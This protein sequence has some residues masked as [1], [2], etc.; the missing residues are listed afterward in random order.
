MPKFLT[1]E[2]LPH[3]YN[4]SDFSPGTFFLF[5]MVKE[6][7]VNITLTQD[8]FKGNWEWAIRTIST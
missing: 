7:R 5:P 8:A 4:S 6:Q 2:Q 3:H 1:K